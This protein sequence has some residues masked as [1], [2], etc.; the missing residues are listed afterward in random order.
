MSEYHSTLLDLQDI[1]ISETWTTTLSVKC[2]K[3]WLEQAVLSLG[4]APAPACKGNR[5]I[6]MKRLY[7]K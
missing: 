7:Q 4:Q 5:S 1:Q 3:M 2:Q 6:E